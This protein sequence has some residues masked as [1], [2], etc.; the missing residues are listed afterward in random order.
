MRLYSELAPWFHLLTHP[1]DYED[2]ADHIVRVVDATIEGKARTLLELG[3]GGGN[4][5]SHLKARFACTLTDVSPEMLELSRTLNPECE[6]IQGDMRA[7]RLGS[8]FDVVLVHDAVAY[9]TTED[10][11]RAVLETLSAHL[12]PGGVGV[13]VPDTTAELFA[14]GTRHGGHDGNDG[15]SL[16]YLEWAHDPDPGDATYDVEFVVVLME[17]TKPVRVEHD[18][19]TCGVFPDAVWRDLIAAAGLELVDVEAVDDPN[20]G[21]HAMFVARKPA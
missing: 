9:M 11:L 3:S 13:L 1:S 18:H 7:L 20:T 4:N 19:H 8:T 5:A 10:D 6:H 14:P 16:R 21:E 12:R 2:E 17:K 15:R